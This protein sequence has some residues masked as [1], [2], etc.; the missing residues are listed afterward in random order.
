MMWWFFSS[1]KAIT[2]VQNVLLTVLETSRIK[3]FKAAGEFCNCNTTSL[4][5]A[6]F[7]MASFE[8]ISGSLSFDRL[9]LLWTSCVEPSYVHVF[10]VLKQVPIYFSCP[11]ETPNTILLQSSRNVLW[12][13]EA[14]PDFALVWKREKNRTLWDYNIKI[15]LLWEYIF[16][17]IR[18]YMM[19]K[20][21]YYN[22]VIFIFKHLF[23]YSVMKRITWK[24]VD[25]SGK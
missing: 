19:T 10:Y 7:Q 18:T 5:R 23:C 25:L 1:S 8:I 3:A 21:S 20:P 4:H 9:L 22:N 13:C 6:Q 16:P 15:V 2:Y 17:I 11:G 12:N 14:S 24:Y